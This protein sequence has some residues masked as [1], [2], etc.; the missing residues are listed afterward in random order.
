MDWHTISMLSPKVPD[1]NGIETIVRNLVVTDTAELNQTSYN[2]FF[3]YFDR[4][5]FQ[6][7]IEQKKTP[8]TVAKLNIVDTGVFTH[9]PSK[10]DWIA[11]TANSKSPCKDDVEYLLEK[12]SWSLINDGDFP[13][14]DCK[15]EKPILAGYTLPCLHSDIFCQPTLKHPYTIAWFPEELC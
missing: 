6:V 9:Q 2:S 12:D 8:F 1:T 3:N 15:V 5:S 7:Q 10:Y 13:D 14:Y 11:F 4:L